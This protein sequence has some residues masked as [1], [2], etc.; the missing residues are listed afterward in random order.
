MIPSHKQRIPVKPKEISKA[1][2]AIVNMAVIIVLKIFESPKKN[3]FIVAVMKA[4][5]KKK[6][7]MI[8]NKLRP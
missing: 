4:T 8:F 3:N 1:V 5:I 6:S 7:Q 2:L